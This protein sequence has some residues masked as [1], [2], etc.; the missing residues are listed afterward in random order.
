MALLVTLDEVKS[1]AQ[2]DTAIQALTGS[3]D[4]VTVVEEIVEAMTSE[5]VFLSL[6]KQA[7]LY[8]Y[9]HLLSLSAQP[10][11]GRGPLS[12]ESVGGISQSFTLPYLN[13][14]TVLGS[15]QYGLMFM[16]IR[17][18]CVPPFAVVVL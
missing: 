3:E 12:S 5:T 14:K 13:Q 6:L 2:S 18:M 16:E 7:Q 17:D 10:V 9:A 8:L 15:T 11:G 1:I 4:V